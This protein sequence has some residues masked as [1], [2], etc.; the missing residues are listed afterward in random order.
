MGVT[1]A[2]R[3]LPVSGVVI[4]RNEADRIERCV[5]SLTGL[6]AEVV[7]LDSGSTDDT[8]ARA[9]AIGARVEHQ[10]WLGFSSQKNVAISLPSP[11]GVL[12]PDAEEGLVPRG[13]RRVRA[14]WDRD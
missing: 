9:R 7:V 6:C 8:V 5:R 14:R 2:E 1:D 12:V 4:A 11:P 13:D 3:A 10:E